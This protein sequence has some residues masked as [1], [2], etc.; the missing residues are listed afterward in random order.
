MTDAAAPQCS[1]TA[2]KAGRWMRLA[3]VNTLAAMTIAVIFT[4][5]GSRTSFWR[6]L[7]SSL[8]F[9]HTIGTL[10]GLI[11]PS[12]G[13]RLNWDHGR[14]A[15]LTLSGVLLAS[16]AVGCVVATFINVG[17]GLVPASAVGRVLS[18]SLVICGFV[19]LGF[20]GGITVYEVTRARLQTTRGELRA[21]E[22]ERERA[23]KLLAEARLAS[24]E[25]RL[26]PHFLFNTLNAISAL[27]PEDPDGA[28]KLVEQLAAVLRFSLD[29]SAS[30]TVPL[31]TEIEI[32][33]AYLGIEQ[34]RLG[35][36]LHF[37]IDLPAELESCAVPPLALH[38]FVQNSVKHVAA[39]RSEP[40]EIR[41]R[42]EARDGRLWLGVWDAGPSFSL[43][44]VPPGHGLD[45]LRARLDVL[46]GDEGRLDVE[47]AGGGKVVS[48]S[49]PLRAG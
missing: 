26:H 40:T 6:E 41:V 10:A 45:A 38:T 31:R 15:L 37:A 5:A 27:I 39:T 30:H 32:V 25:S 7:A 24:L 20:G 22:V 3:V 17:V 29:A 1:D 49:L 43:D 21:R 34:A 14:G 35:A 42:G 9:S 28:E 48:L 19:T 13:R 8:I 47:A 4:A 16:A 2:S 36:R 23:E 46:Y 18:T 12:V 11:V 33:R 44:T